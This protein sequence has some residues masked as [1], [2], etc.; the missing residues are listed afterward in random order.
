MRW[1]PGKTMTAIFFVDV[2]T[3]YCLYLLLNAFPVLQVIRAQGKY[4]NLFFLPNLAGE[5]K[6]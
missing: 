5:I 4:R 2:N 1:K 3:T 6:L